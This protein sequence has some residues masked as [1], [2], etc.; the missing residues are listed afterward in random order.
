M[1]FSHVGLVMSSFSR[2]VRL[3]MAAQKLDLGTQAQGSLLSRPF[4]HL[5]QSRA[6]PMQ[7]ANATACG[8]GK[9]LEGQAAG[10]LAE[11]TFATFRPPRRK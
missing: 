11:V 6:L 1:L 4:G 3:S 7:Q 8:F 10:R 9:F 2:V 5:A